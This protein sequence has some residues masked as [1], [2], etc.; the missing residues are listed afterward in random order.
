[1]TDTYLSDYY[2]FQPIRPVMLEVGCFTRTC[3]TEWIR[4]YPAGRAIMVE[5]DPQNYAKLEKLFAIASR[6]MF[7]THRLAI[8]DM[9]GIVPFYRYGHEQWHSTTPRA[10]K[11]LV[12]TVEVECCTLKTLL[13]KCRV[14]ICDLLLLNCEGG[15]IPA[16]E[17]LAASESLRYR[18]RQVCTSFHCDHIHLY[19]PA[20]RDKLLSALSEWYDIR[21]GAFKPIPYYLF[22][23]KEPA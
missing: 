23:R 20:V 4:H 1:M 17:Q 18:V 3:A 12:E 5:P 6:E 11:P 14:D 7:Q 22:T 19:A 16:L 21:Q 9:D 13:D 2:F 10:D 8:G 15:E